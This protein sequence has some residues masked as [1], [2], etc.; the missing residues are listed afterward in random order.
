MKTFDSSS[1]PNH[2]MARGITA[3]ARHA[4][5]YV[6]AATCGSSVSA[7]SYSPARELWTIRTLLLLASTHFFAL[8]AGYPAHTYSSA[9]GSVCCFTARSV[10]PPLRAKTAT[11]NARLSPSPRLAGRG[12][13]R[14]GFTCRSVPPRPAAPCPRGTRARRRRPSTRATPCWRR[15]PSSRPTRNRRRR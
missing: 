5:T 14:G 6:I 7:L 10:W 12:S 1:I 9:S 13:G 3:S 8:P 4:L 15:P 2:R 11:E